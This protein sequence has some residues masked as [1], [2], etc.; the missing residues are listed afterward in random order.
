MYSNKDVVSKWQNAASETN[1]SLRGDSA[2]SRQIDQLRECVSLLKE[3]VRKRKELQKTQQ[4]AHETV[5]FTI[6]A[7]QTHDEEVRNHAVDVIHKLSSPLGGH[8]I[9]V[10]IF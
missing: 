2:N 7:I 4:I 5:E 6:P 3:A 9:E 1:P 10:S 8:R